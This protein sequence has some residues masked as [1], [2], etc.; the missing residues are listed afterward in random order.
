MSSDRALRKQQQLN[1]L[2]Y[3]V[4]NQAKPGDRIVDFCSEM[5]FYHIGQAGV[6]FLTSSDP[7]ALASQSARIT[8]VSHCTQPSLYYYCAGFKLL[9]SGD[10]PA[11]ASQSAG[12]TGVS[13]RTQRVKQ[14]KWDDSIM[15]I[16]DFYVAH[17]ILMSTQL[18]AERRPTERSFCLQAG[19]PNV[20]SALSREEIHTE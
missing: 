3:V 14:E 5:G 9:T 7:P 15:E 13:H 20:R 2:V 19:H 18:S 10:P 12:I 8:G 11:S 1:N 17:V 4:T 16:V 6:K